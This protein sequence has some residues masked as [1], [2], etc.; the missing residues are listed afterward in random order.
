MIELF[1]QAYSFVT[2]KLTLILIGVIVVLIALMAVDKATIK[3]VKA[4]RDRETLNVQNLT[5]DRDNSV[6]KLNLTKEQ[7]EKSNTDWKHHTDSLIKANDIKLRQIKSTVIYKTE[8]K[9]TGSVKIVYKTISAKPDGSYVIPVSYD[10]N[11][12]GFSGQILSKDYASK[13]N[14]LER[15]SSNTAQILRTEKRFLGFLWITKREERVFNECGTIQITDIT[16]VK[17]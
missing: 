9:D 10:S 5:K 15:R 16:I 2:S 17:K 14:I 7:F 3:S 12:W 11:C 13:L 6:V 1:K 4:D 8:Y